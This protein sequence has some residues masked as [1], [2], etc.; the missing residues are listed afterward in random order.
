MLKGN[1]CD[2]FFCKNDKPH[3]E[4]HTKFRQITGYLL[5][6]ESLDPNDYVYLKACTTCGHVVEG[7]V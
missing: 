1:K 3:R 5:K 7:K 2:C 4:T 6:A